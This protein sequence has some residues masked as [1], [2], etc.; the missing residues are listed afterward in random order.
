MIRVL[1]GDILE[2]KAQTITNTVN[3]VGIM[4]KGI[5]AEFKKKYP[6]MYEDYKNRCYAKKIQPGQPYPYFDKLQ[7]ITIINF[8]TKNH[9]RSPSHLSDIIKG[10]DYFIAHI[11]DWKIQSLAMPPLGCGNGGLDWAVVGPIIYQK[12]A[13]LNIPIEI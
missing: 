8:P 1:I 3:C 11:T 7:N 2:S 6:A 9:W 13:N 5:A 10:L 12:L 4:G